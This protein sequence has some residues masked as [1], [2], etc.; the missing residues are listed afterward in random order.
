MYLEEEILIR[1]SLSVA[2]VPSV[3]QYGITHRKAFVYILNR[4]RKRGM[5]VTEHEHLRVWLMYCSLFQLSLEIGQGAKAHRGQ[6]RKMA[7]EGI[8][9]PRI[10]TGSNY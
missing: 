3:N 1:L 4:R 8:L 6:G 9:I 5:H 10:V 7:S 2:L